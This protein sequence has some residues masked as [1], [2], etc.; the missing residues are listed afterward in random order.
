[1]RSMT[2]R[3]LIVPIEQTTSTMGKNRN[4]N[5]GELNTIGQTRRTLPDRPIE[6]QSADDKNPR[7]SGRWRKKSEN[8]DDNNNHNA[9]PKLK[10]DIHFQALERLIGLLGR[11]R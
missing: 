8:G 7:K 11:R 5:I 9:E 10:G 6:R 4:R 3:N 2:L 1:M